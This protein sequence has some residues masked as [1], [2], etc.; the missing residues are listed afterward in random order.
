METYMTRSTALLVLGLAVIGVSTSAG[1]Q[2]IGGQR[3][4]KVDSTVD[5][6]LLVK[7][8]NNWAQAVIKRDAKAIRALVDPRW[9]YTDESGTMT[10]EQGITAFTT[11][12]DTVRQAGN[13]GM[14]IILHG[15]DVAVV[16]G[17]LW[18]RGRGPNGDFVHRY[19]YTD[20]WRREQ[21]VWRCIASQ[22]YLLPA[23]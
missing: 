20:V 14:N 22:D 5:E 12:T 18:M 3:I 4:V 23:S 6:R 11:G 1:A 15:K 21:G 8:E 2:S 19:R 10:R 7:A 16:T 17:V 13:D 9:V